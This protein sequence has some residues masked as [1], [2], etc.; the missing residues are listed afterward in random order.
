MP[1]YKSKSIVI[2]MV[3]N[4]LVELVRK[5]K[6]VR[7]ILRDYDIDGSEEGI[8]KDEYGNYLETEKERTI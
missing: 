5:P 3:K 7:I 6:E 4:G 1:S 8:K 2:L